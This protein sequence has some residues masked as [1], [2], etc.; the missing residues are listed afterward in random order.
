VCLA[1]PDAAASLS[2]GPQRL[3]LR[4]E[5]TRGGIMAMQCGFRI[6]RVGAAL[7]IL[8][9]AAIAPADDSREA[10]QQRAKALFGVLPAEAPSEA[11]PITDA[12]IELGRQ[13]YFDPR[14]SINGKISCNSCHLLDK[15]GVDNE[16]TS[17]GHEGKRGARNSP[18]VYNAAFHFAQ[19]WDGRAAD[20]EEQAQGP[21]LNPV[22]MGMP[23]AAFVLKVLHSIPGYQPLFAN[24][25]PGEQDPISYDNFGRAIGA[26]ERRLTTPSPFDAFLGGN[27]DA[28]S[29]EQVAGLAKFIETGCPTCH[30]GPTVGGLMFQKLGAVN[31]YETADTGR[32]EVTKKESDKYLF[33]VPSLRNSAETGPWFHDGSVPTLDEAIR[34][35]AWHQL[36]KKL[37]PADV[38]S[39][40]AFLGSLTGKPDAAYIAK[41]TPLPSG[42]TTPKPD[43]G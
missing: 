27:L 5:F 26:F 9:S 24:A 20:V 16:A 14:I 34:L 11:N 18:T 23:D 13:L 12:K 43:Q 40:A 6:A 21:V 33:K 10:V 25:F 17:P 39:I 31:P 29:A 38:A 4:I 41:P 7:L 2:R 15:F 28:L 35:M 32:Q 19:F 30:M 3:R 22:E 8:S 37:E 1:A 42:P 36:G